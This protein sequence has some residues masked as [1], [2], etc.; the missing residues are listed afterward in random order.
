MRKINFEQD[1][2]L[3]KKILIDSRKLL[4]P[5][6]TIFFAL[7]GKYHHGNSFIA[8]LYEQGVRCFVTDTSLYEDRYIDA[9]FEVVPNPL[10]L[11][12]AYATWHRSKFN[13]PV[14][15]ITGS[16]GK[17]IV[18]E[19]LFQLLSKDFL[20]VKSPKSYN[21]QIGVPLSVLEM[22]EGHN[23]GVFEAGISQPQEMER[24]E[25]I[26]KPTIGI[27]T[28]IGEAHGEGF[29]NKEQKIAEKLKL[30]KDCP[31][32]I[33]SYEYKE[34]VNAIE[35]LEGKELYSWGKSWEAKIPT[36]VKQR[37]AQTFVEL[38]WKQ[39]KYVFDLPFVSAAA[40]ENS[41]HCIVTLLYLG[42]SLEQIQQRLK[43]LE[44][45]AR[46]LE[47]KVGANDCTII[48][49]S[50]NNDWAGLQIALNFLRQKHEHHSAVVQTVVLSDLL[51][52]GIAE[53]QLY[54]QVAELLE[55]YKIS[56]FIGVGKAIS[57][58]KAYFKNIKEVYFFENTKALL[59]G[60]ENDLN[61][62]NE[63]ILVKG[64]RVFE[65]EQVVQQLCE[66]LHD[67]VLEIDLEALAHNFNFYRSLLLPATKMMVMV[68]A[69][70]YGSDGY[71]VARL[72]QYHHADYLGVAYTDEAVALRQKGIY[73]PIMIMNISTQH[74]EQLLKHN[75]EPV[76]YSIRILKAFVT[77]LKKTKRKQPH[78]IHIELDTGMRRLGFGLDELEVLS[79]YLLEE[80][81][82]VKVVSVFSHL[83]GA[84]DST[85]DSFSREQLFDFELFAEGLERKIGYTVIKHILNSAGIS[86][87]GN[88]Q[89]DMVRLGIGLH[90]ID[91]TYSKKLQVTTSLKTRITQ[92]KTLA[93]GGTVGY[94][95]KGKVERESRIA[96]LAIGY[97]DG[98][99]RAF[100][101]GL[102]KVCI[103]GCLVPTVGN[104]CMDMCFVDVTDIV[105]QEGDEV[106]VFGKLPTIKDLAEAIG[107]IPYEILT[108]VSQRVP[109]VFFEA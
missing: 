32:L 16:N 25:K 2:W 53:K 99:L 23:L 52:A 49:D 79:S 48:D 37:E 7:S 98:Y 11:L 68:K 60:L 106:V 81:E 30:F 83:A 12:Q 69:F 70:A 31:V 90:G 29:K 74:F 3:D 24:L 17:T 20:V 57:K 88:K 10:E 18:K 65:F 55:Y 71:E 22:Q 50:Y 87:F 41:I 40:I 96:T 104:I 63:T 91:P 43:T 97:A 38:Y 21:S 64:A 14:V 39:Q 78:A 76:I 105:A 15:A 9:V 72:L 61:F 27:F 28:N 33:Y 80:Q 51:E 1:F 42:L 109:R 89:L 36:F 77:F 46:R 35:Q 67:T 34:L 19:W 58:Q 44:N 6:K 94:S 107:T 59:Q 103:N 47:L 62:R 26:I 102:G 5:A 92:I 93:A 100:G 84:E 66:Q 45:V 54:M 108:N 4:Y 75:L 95:R 101:N 8:T 85:H 56:K 86:R 82:V 13:Y 73:L